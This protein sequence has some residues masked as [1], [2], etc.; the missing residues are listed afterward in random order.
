MPLVINHNPSAA[1]ISFSKQRNWWVFLEPK[2]AEKKML[3]MLQVLFLC[4][5]SCLHRLSNQHRLLVINKYITGE[6]LGDKGQPVS[7]S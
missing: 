1:F 6:Q 3:F 7:E 5:L 4:L 2:K